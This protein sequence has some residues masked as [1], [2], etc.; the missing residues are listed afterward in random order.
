MQIKEDDKRALLGTVDFE[1]SHAN[2]GSDSLPQTED[3]RYPV[4]DVGLDAR[5]RGGRRRRVFHFDDD[6]EVQ[7]KREERR[8]R[9]DQSQ[10]SNSSPNS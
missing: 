6:A 9:R 1:S 7:R 3:Q 4:L 8:R 10:S 2:P 5:K